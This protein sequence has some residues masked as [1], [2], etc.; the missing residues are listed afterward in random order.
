[1]NVELSRSTQQYQARRE[2]KARG[3]GVLCIISKGSLDWGRKNHTFPV[4]AIRAILALVI[5]A[6]AVIIAL[7]P[8]VLGITLPVIGAAGTVTRALTV[9]VSAIT[10]PVTTVVVT[11]PAIMVAIVSI[12]SSRRVF[13]TAPT[14][15]RGTTPAGRRTVTATVTARIE[16]PGRGRRSARPLGKI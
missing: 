3:P 4:F 8:I 12:V 9:A 11:I 15:R 1:M 14:R 2:Q 16:S 10:V 5:T 7:F 13:P 6:L